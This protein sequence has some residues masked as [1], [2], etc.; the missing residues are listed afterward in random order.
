MSIWG[1]RTAKVGKTFAEQQRRRGMV[2]P[3]S[4]PSF[5]PQREAGHSL[6]EANLPPSS[7]GTAAA[8][9]HKRRV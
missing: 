4:T 1:G 3:T 9:Y 5:I 2:R 8:L 7:N 6:R